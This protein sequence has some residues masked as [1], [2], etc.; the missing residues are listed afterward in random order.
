MHWVRLPALL[1]HA[2]PIGVEQRFVGAV[3][4]RRLWN[5]FWH[6]TAFTRV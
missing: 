3:Q 4:V 6:R 1:D 5:H 2:K